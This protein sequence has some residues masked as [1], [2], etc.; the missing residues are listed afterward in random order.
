MFIVK[1]ADGTAIETHHT[2]KGQLRIR[3]WA[4]FINKIGAYIEKRSGRVYLT[5]KN[6]IFK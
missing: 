1:L 6:S 2:K 3:T 4:I 5:H